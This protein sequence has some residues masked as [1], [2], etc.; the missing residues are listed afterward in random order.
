MASQVTRSGQP[1]A[2]QALNSSGRQKTLRPM[3]IGRGIL[4]VV[5][6]V[7]HV[8]T[9]V[10]NSAATSGAHSRRC[11]DVLL[12]HSR[13]GAGGL[14]FSMAVGISLVLRMAFW[15]D[16]DEGEAKNGSCAPSISLPTRS[17]FEL[18]KKGP[19]KE[20]AA[21]LSTAAGC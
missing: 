1:A 17:K 19:R 6:Q 5:F 3:W 18:P 9:D 10:F 4:P 7:R 20:R 15:F 21:V 11:V 2:T 8:R 16:V 13:Q 12:L 14:L